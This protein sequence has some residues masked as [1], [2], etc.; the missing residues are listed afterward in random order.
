MLILDKKGEKIEVFSPKETRLLL[1]QLREEG[2]RRRNK[3]SSIRLQS[4]R[5]EEIAKKII[6][7]RI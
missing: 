3:S 2:Q 1:E 7:L 4:P 6:Q 5:G